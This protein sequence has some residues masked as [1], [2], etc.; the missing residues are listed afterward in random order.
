[1]T[2][3]YGAVEAPN[4]EPVFGWVAKEALAEAP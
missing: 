1:M 4:C 3:I 2:F